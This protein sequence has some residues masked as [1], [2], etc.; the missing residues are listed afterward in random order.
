MR[1]FFNGFE[2]ERFMNMEKMQM[3]KSRRSIFIVYF[4]LITIII[5]SYLL[6][7]FLFFFFLLLLKC[8]EVFTSRWWQDWSLFA[9]R[10]G[11]RK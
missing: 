10:R 3:R 7:F 6:F 5:V 9:V 2:M 4:F 1:I 8:V 11:K